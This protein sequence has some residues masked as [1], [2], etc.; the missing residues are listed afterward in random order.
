[1]PETPLTFSTTFRPSHFEQQ[2]LAQIRSALTEEL[3]EAVTTLQQDSAIGATG[4]YKA[5]W[6]LIPAR[7]LPG[8][9]ELQA[10]IRNSSEH[11][12][13]AARGRGPGKFPPYK[14][15]SPL[16]AWAVT[17]GIPAFLVARKIAREGTKLWQQGDGNNPAGL[18]RDGSIAPNSPIAQ[19]ERRIEARLRSVRVR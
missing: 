6:S 14:P 9:F 3:A 17:K 1:M 16:A 15:G 13:Y 11:T 18:K 10:T 8:S 5:G 4:E 7:R 12:T 19:A 2:V